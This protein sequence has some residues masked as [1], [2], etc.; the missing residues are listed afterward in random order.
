[1]PRPGADAGAAEPLPE[2]TP[3]TESR[4]PPTQLGN[5]LTASFWAGMPLGTHW[6]RF[7]RHERRFSARQAGDWLHGELRSSSSLG[8][9]VT[10]RQALKLLGKFLR[11][12]VVEDLGGR[13][14][15]ERVRDGGQLFRFPAPRGLRA[16]SR[17]RKLPRVKTRLLQCPPY[18][19]EFLRRVSIG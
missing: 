19:A 10:R 17:F 9:D 15:S 16:K 5:E 14:G 1:M 18:L 7:R 8:P 3:S 13:W 6:Q 4:G 2:R 11:T 12:H